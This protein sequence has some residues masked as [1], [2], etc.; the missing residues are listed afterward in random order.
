MAFN[1]KTWKNRNSQYPTRRILTRVDT[2]ASTTYD[3]TRDEGT[4]TEAGDDFSAENMNALEQRIADQVDAIDDIVNVYGAK[5]LIPYPYSKMSTTIRGITW[6]DNGD[7]GI[8]GNGTGTEASSQPYCELNGNQTNNAKD[9]LL[10]ANTWY[11]LTCKRTSPYAIGA[12]IYFLD[13]ST[14]QQTSLTYDVIYGTDAHSTTRN[15]VYMYVNNVVWDEVKFRLPQD[16]YAQV[17][18]RYKAG[19]N[20]TVSNDVQYPMLRLASIQDDT[21]EPY[22]KTNKQLTDDSANKVDLTNI[23]ITGTTNNT[24]STISSGTFFYKDGDLAQAKTSIANGATL[25]LNTNYELVTAGGLNNLNE[26]LNTLNASLS[27]IGTAVGGTI[28]SSFSIASNANANVGEITLNKGL[29]L[30]IAGG[31]CP[32]T[33]GFMTF[34]GTASAGWGQTTPNSVFKFNITYVVNITSDNTKKYLNYTN[35][36]GTATSVPGGYLKAYRIK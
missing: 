26:G 4:V 2:Q 17:Q 13:P 12:N 22:A 34:D 10:K 18:V 8:V 19:T 23:S 9:L 24:G 5:N 7:G 31:W 27:N 32:T 30:V 1:K 29:W 16:M 15:N 11:A 33:S 14:M 20:V 6:S 28:Y 3:V 25:T 35:Y 36:N 21:Y